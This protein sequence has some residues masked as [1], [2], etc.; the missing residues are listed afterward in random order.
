[1][2]RSEIFDNYAQ[3]NERLG[4]SDTN[5]N[6]RDWHERERQR[7]EEKARQEREYEARQRNTRW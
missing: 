6:D 1:M 7:A 3:R 2:D 5:Q 4:W